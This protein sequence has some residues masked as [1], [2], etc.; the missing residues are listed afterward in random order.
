MRLEVVVIY[1]LCGFFNFG[2][3]GI[4]LGGLGVLVFSWK[5]DLVFIVFR[6]M[7]VG[8]VVCFMIGCVVGKSS[9]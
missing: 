1:V 4:L 5:F 6:V 7:I 9:L 3:M 8:S 2:F